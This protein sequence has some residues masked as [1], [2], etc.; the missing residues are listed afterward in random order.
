MAVLL[1]ALMA[2]AKVVLL[3]NL[4]AAYLVD[5]LESQKVVE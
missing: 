1:A 5:Q 2:D 3:E 4:L